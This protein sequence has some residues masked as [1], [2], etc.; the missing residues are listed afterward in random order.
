M[1]PLK[2]GLSF[3]NWLFRIGLLVMLLTLFVS[4][5]SN[6]TPG[7][8]EFYIALAFVASGLLLFIGG[9]MSKPNITIISGSVIVGLSVFKIISLYAGA[10]NPLM[11][12]FLIILSVGFYFICTGNN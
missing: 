8:K 11:A 2:N 3:A 6:F 1:K 12:S 4:R 7:E 9:F 10:F 5:L